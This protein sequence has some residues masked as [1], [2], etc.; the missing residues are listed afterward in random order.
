M[1]VL[2]HLLKMQMVVAVVENAD[3]SISVSYRY[4]LMP[5]AATPRITKGLKVSNP[6]ATTAIRRTPPLGAPGLT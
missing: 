3:G 1:T 5:A 6:L 2:I 4:V